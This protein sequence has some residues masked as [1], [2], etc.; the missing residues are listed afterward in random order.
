MQNRYEVQTP[1]FELS[2]YTGMTKRHYIECAKYILERAFK[3]VDS[4]DT[5]LSFPRVPGKTYPQ[6]DAPAWRY[7]SFAVSYTHLTLPT[8]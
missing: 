4:M 2:P 8:N 1:D 7:R 6:P 3:H 5:P